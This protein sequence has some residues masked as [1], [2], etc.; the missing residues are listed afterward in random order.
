MKSSESRQRAELE[1]KTRL[2]TDNK[3]DKRYDSKANSAKGKLGGA[4]K[5]SKNGFGSMTKEQLRELAA[6]ATHARKLNGVGHRIPRRHML[7]RAAKAG[8]VRLWVQL[9]KS[10]VLRGGTIDPP[11]DYDLI[12]I[13][14]IQ[15]VHPSTYEPVLGFPSLFSITVWDVTD[16]AIAE[17]LIHPP[18]PQNAPKYAEVRLLGRCRV[19]GENE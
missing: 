1:M 8:D 11:E 9:G 14:S 19:K 15:A 2:L 17:I 3:Y 16:Q 5:G 12:T 10:R 6:K 4:P 13:E 18:L 7:A